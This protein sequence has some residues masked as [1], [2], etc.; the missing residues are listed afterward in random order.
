MN[1]IV[2]TVESSVRC[3]WLPISNAVWQYGL[4]HSFQMR[5]QFGTGSY[6]LGTKSR[7]SDN[8]NEYSVKFRIA[9]QYVQTKSKSC[10]RFLDNRMKQGL[11]YRTVR[12]V[13]LL[14]VFQ[15]SL[16]GS[17]LANRHVQY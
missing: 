10:V 13:F 6:S 17:C 1:E 3:S 11:V 9:C 16:V 5:P 14:P 2:T 7:Y 8:C 4:Q 15:M 12:D